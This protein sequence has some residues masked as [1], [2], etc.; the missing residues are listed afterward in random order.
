MTNASAQNNVAV[1]GLK[2]SVTN[3]LARRR[4]LLIDGESVDGRATLAVENPATGEPLAEVAQAGPEEVARA[5]AC[6]RAAFDDGHWR[7]LSG[8]T[9]SR[10]ILSARA[11]IDGHA[12]ELAQL[13]AL[14]A[15][16]PLVLSR[17]MHAA[18]VET[19]EYAA[20]IPTRLA[21]E[22]LS[23]ANLRGD[24][25]QAQVLREPVGVI[26]LIV[27]WNAPL[28]TTI[29][30]ITFCLATGN[31][32]VLKPAEQAPLSALRIGELF[33]EAGLP[34]GILNVVPGLGPVAGAALVED[35]RIDRVAFTGS[36]ATGKQI[37][38]A[39][40]ENLTPVS[41][42][43]GGKSPNIVFADGD[44]EAA[45]QASASNA[46][47]LSGQMCTAASRTF[48][49]RPVFDD[50]VSGLR[51][52]AGALV[53]GQ[54][55]DPATTMGPVISSAQRE[56]VL[57]Y[58]HSGVKEGAVVLYGGTAVEGP[59]Y[60]ISPTILLST[61]REMVVEREEIFGPVVSV[62]PFDTVDEVISR[63][64]DTPYGLAAGVWTNNLKI[65]HRMTRELQVGNVWING[66][67]LFDP[68]LP[69]GGFKHSGWG[70]DYGSGAIEQFTRTKTA[71]T[72]T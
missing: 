52:A 64:N 27:P 19:M 70:R 13:D 43:L 26:A 31:T 36:T 35:P 37:V 56:R 55:F 41:L 66:Y 12:E 59:G 63:A 16:V 32:V 17:A 51:A 33:V 40:A 8:S 48:V 6:A 46:F 25:F 72:A 42:E 4:P 68:A 60:Y 58:V 15:G 7:W 30:K 67:N 53:L 14:D 18:A 5:V 62:T 65:A 11:T 57:G 1:N 24:Q 45:L 38:A 61:T 29:E 47:I 54:P 23:P 21:G 71:V 10:L 34:P 20:G 2:P 50:F 3:W 49:E 22:A 9:R 39:A 69:F 28:S 44:L